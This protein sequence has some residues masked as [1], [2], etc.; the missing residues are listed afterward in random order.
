MLI[1]STYQARTVT[2]VLYQVRVPT[3]HAVPGTSTVRR[4]NDTDYI[5]YYMGRSVVGPSVP[6]TSS[7]PPFSLSTVLLF[8]MS[9]Q[10]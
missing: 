5:S 4:T 8:E 10:S 6:D 1:P 7:S 9:R 3:V 2:A